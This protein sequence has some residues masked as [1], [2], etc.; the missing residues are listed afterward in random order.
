VHEKEEFVLGRNEAYIGVLI[1]DLITKG[2]EEP[3]RMFTSRAEYRILLRQDNADLRLTRKGLE[4]G[5]AKEE[6]KTMLNN[7]ISSM[8]SITAFIK[9]TKFS[10][11]VINPIL[12]KLGTATIKEKISFDALIR[13]PNIGIKDFIGIDDEIKNFFAQHKYDA[14][15]QVEILAKYETYIDKEEKLA[16]KITQLENMR[17]DQDFDYTQINALSAEAKQKLSK[18]K[19]S[20]IGQ[21]SRISGVNPADISILMVYLEKI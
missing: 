10:P 1:D 2:T 16:D 19:P 6:R 14:I 9:K 8:E 18:F 20:T 15:E 21:A 4:L 12:E 13:R 5:L 17:L 11:D 7:K 3:Y